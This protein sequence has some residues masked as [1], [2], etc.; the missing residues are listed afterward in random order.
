M[1]P[2]M[3]P[4]FGFLPLPEGYHQSEIP[5]L[6]ANFLQQLPSRQSG[7]RSQK[8]RPRKEHDQ[9]EKVTATTKISPNLV[10]LVIGQ[11]GRTIKRLSKE[12]GPRCYIKHVG[13]GEFEV[14]A[15]TQETCDKAIESIQKFEEQGDSREPKEAIEKV[16]LT[17]QIDA[18]LVGL[19]IGAGGNTIKRLSREAGDRC[20]IKHVGDGEFEVSAPTED[21]CNKAIESIKKFD[22]EDSS[23]DE[24]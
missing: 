16:T 9:V 14:S 6:W 13:N 21:I 24:E 7:N 8:R 2:P 20:F 22:E 10:G 17:T 23:S 4:S 1:F 11:A 5:Q 15:L 3:M 12:A 19:V 18:E